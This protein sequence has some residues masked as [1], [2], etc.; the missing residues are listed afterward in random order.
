MMWIEDLED[1][2]VG[3]LKQLLQNSWMVDVG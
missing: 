2:I 1:K 3:G